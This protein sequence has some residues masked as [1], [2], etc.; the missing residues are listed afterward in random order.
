[1]A[2]S[3]SYIEDNI[4]HAVNKLNSIP[5]YNDKFTYE[6][7]NENDWFNII[8]SIQNEILTNDELAI[9]IADI[10]CEELVN[11]KILNFSIY[12]DENIMTFI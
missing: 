7:D 4:I 2:D 12:E 1:M 3:H 11:K 6:Y 9:K 8:H 5:G 10:L